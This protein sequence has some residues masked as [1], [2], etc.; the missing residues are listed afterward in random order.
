MK[1]NIILITGDSGIAQGKQNI[2][3]EM[4]REFSKYFNSV[5]VITA[6][7]ADGQ[8]FLIHKN[9]YVH[10]SNKV[11]FLRWDFWTHADFVYKKALEIN[12]IYPL[13]FIISHVIPPFFPGT[14]G[15]ILASKKLCIPHFAEVMHIPGYPEYGT[16]REKFERF[17]MANFLKR[18]YKIFDKIRII[19]KIDVK[20]F[21]LK[22]EI[23]ESKLLE[24]PAFYLDFQTFKNYPEIKR[25]QNQ[26]VFAGRFDRNK[27]IFSLL[28][29]YKN[30]SKDFEIKL[31][32]IG[33][34]FLKH[35]VE[36]FC[37]DLP[38]VELLGWLPTQK[39]VAKIYAESIALVMPSFSEGGPR[40]TLEAMAC[41]A[42]VLSTRVGIMKE[43]L[44]DKRNGLAIDFSAKD[45]EEKMRFILENPDKVSVMAKKGMERVKEF[46]YHKAIGFYARTYL[47]QIE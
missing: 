9:V 6:A 47:A 37:K 16:L 8:S 44:E 23:P 18:N 21:L 30:L 20:G 28:E 34:G 13:S 38:G 35:K 15:G 11:D 39:D 27:N 42:L 40:V 45:I 17:C 10:P 31:K 26:F 46:E 12:K 41:G 3:Y 2:F 32:I 1:H 43:V 22:N 14:R 7:N 4:L 33:D 29:A 36:S 25:A 24:I 19:N 5:H